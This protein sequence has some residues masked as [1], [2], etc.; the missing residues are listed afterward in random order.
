MSSSYHQSHSR[1]RSHSRSHSHSRSYSHSPHMP[2]AVPYA[3]SS[4]IA[5]PHHSSVVPTGYAGSSYSSGYSPTQGHHQYG[6]QPLLSVPSHSYDHRHRS[7]TVT[8]VPMTYS[9]SH[10]PAVV[11]ST[12]GSSSGRKHKHGHSHHSSSRRSRSSDPVRMIEYPGYSSS[13]RY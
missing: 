6:S 4:A 3:S 8:A 11:I 12:S 2:V 10:V 5:I 13:A 7:S 9:S 1:P